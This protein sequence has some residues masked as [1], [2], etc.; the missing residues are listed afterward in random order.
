MEPITPLSPP[1]IEA[2]LQSMD[3]VTN[4][5]ERCCITVRKAL[6]PSAS[7]LYLTGTRLFAEGIYLKTKKIEKGTCKS[8]RLI[9]PLPA[10]MRENASGLVVAKLRNLLKEAHREKKQ[11]D[12]PFYP[13]EVKNFYN[14]AVI[15]QWLR[16]K[17]VPGILNILPLDY[18]KGEIISRRLLMEHCSQGT[19]NCYF[20][21]EK[22]I[23]QRLKIMLQIIQSIE[24]MH[25]HG[26]CHMDLKPTNIFITKEQDSFVTRLGDFGATQPIGTR[27]GLIGTLPAPE[28]IHNELQETDTELLPSL[29]LWVLGDLL[30]SALYGYSLLLKYKL[31]RIV[32]KQDFIQALPHLAPVKQQ[33]R[34]K[35]DPLHSCIADLLSLNPR[36]RPQAHIVAH[37][38][39]QKIDDLTKYPQ[40]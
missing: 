22:N 39:R 19:L 40:N 6:P 1:S 2:T 14:E 10:C 31:T 18:Q 12:P 11:P 33:L 8:I 9:Q 35:N 26:L 7:L 38:V 37:I 17:G 15:S 30:F 13:N 4:S 25:S 27:L 21:D 23:L 29:D 28:M 3:Q 16:K 36:K 24:G 32:E 20:I 5:L 34:E